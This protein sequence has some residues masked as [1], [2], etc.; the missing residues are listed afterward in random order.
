MLAMRQVVHGLVVAAFGAALALG[1][2]HSQGARNADTEDLL[3]AA[4]FNRRPADTPEKEQHLR[5]L[6]QNRLLAYEQNGEFYY[7]YADANGCNCLYAGDEAAYQRYKELA[8]QKKIAADQLEAAQAN[9]DAAMNWDMWG[10]W[11]WW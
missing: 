4:G 1:C 5:S 8:I 11:P 7:V 10:P 6:E 2:A 3:S 9:R